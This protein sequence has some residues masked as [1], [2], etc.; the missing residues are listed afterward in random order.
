MIEGGAYTVQNAG[1]AQARVWQGTGYSGSGAYASAP[2]SPTTSPLIVSGLTAATQTNVEFTTGTVLRPQFEPG[3]VA[4]VFERRPLGVELPLCQRYY[5]R[6]AALGPYAPFGTGAGD[7]A[8]DFRI[9]LNT[10]AP[11][12][13]SPI[14]TYGGSFIWAFGNA[15][16]AIGFVAATVDLIGLGCTTTGVTPNGCYTLT[17]AGS[18]NAWIAGSAEI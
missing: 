8:T 4:T 18:A 15:V 11:M 10:P 6:I 1:T 7:S 12:R 17:D 9:V 5:F 16:T 3:S 14:M 13:A 2:V